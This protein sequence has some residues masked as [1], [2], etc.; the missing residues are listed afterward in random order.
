MKRIFTALSIIMA[1]V[2]CNTA[3]P[4]L[5]EWDT[6]YGIPD[7]NSIQEKHYLP[8][9]EAGISQQQAE[10][11]AIIANP[12]APTFENVVVA[13]ERSG[14]ILDRV[15]NVLFNVSESDA[16]ESLQKIVE[17]ALPLMSVHSDNIFMN[18][19]FFAKVEVLYNDM[20]NLGL[21]REQQMT[22]KKMYNAFVK[23]GVALNEADQAR[24]L[25]QVAISFFRGSCQLRDLTLVFCIAGGFPTA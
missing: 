6:P 13:Y 8:A 1:A 21:D 14:A 11:D 22:L 25:E 18:P 9:V 3:N 2:S 20:D 23:N 7:F 24:I 12:D 10:I 5:T 19:D 15:T 4:F 17:Q 16:T